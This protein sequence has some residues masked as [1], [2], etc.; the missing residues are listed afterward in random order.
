[1]YTSS[2]TVTI[3]TTGVYSLVAGCSWATNTT[4]RRVIYITK[5]GT[6]YADLLAGSNLLSVGGSP[7]SQVTSVNLLTAGDVLRVYVYQDSGVSLN[8]PASTNSYDTNPT[9]FA[10]T[11]LGK[12]A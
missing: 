4:N 12:T 10:V 9:F 1:M 11:F 2:S 3:Q 8:V 7:L 6:G 5:N